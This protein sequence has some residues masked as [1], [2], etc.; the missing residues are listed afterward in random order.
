MH[1]RTR[2]TPIGTDCQLIGRTLRPC[3]KEQKGRGCEVSK[4]ARSVL[5]VMP[6]MVVGRGLAGRGCELG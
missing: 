3:A 4:T 1:K 6:S 5:A 2:F